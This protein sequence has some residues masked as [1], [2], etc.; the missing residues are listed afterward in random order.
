MGY[1]HITKIGLFIIWI[2]FLMITMSFIGTLL[3]VPSTI[4]NIAGV[5][6]IIAVLFISVWFFKQVHKIKDNE[7]SN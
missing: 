4:A 3:T 2:V 1:K 6:V 7:E 5:L